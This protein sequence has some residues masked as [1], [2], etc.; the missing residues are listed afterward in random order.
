MPDIEAML[1]IVPRPRSNIF[2]P[3]SRQHQKTPL[4]FTLMTSVHSSSLVSSAASVAGDAGVIHE[5]VYR[6]DLPIHLFQSWR[7]HFCGSRTSTWTKKALGAPYLS[8]SLTAFSRLKP[9]SYSATTMS[10]P[11]A[12]E[13]AGNLEPNPAPRTRHERGTAGQIESVGHDFPSG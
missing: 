8:N 4:K 11:G 1:T 5:N 13:G 12:G 7:G 10:G 9:L 6:L 3:T 2:L